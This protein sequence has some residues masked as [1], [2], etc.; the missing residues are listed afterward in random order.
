METKRYFLLLFLNI[1]FIPGGFGQDVFYQTVGSKQGLSQSSAISIWQDK[2][3]KIWIGNDALNSFDGE[4]VKVFRLSEYLDGVED[5]YIH[6]LCGNDSILFFLA[7]SQLVCFDLRME[8]FT[9]PGIRTQSIW[10]SNGFLYYV[11][12]GMF[13]KYDWKTNSSTEIIH[14]PSNIQSSQSI[15]EKEED[16]FWLGTPGGI[17]E[18]NIKE[19]AIKNRF[20]NEESILYL[21]KDS[22]DYIWVASQLGQIYIHAPNGQLKPLP[23]KNKQPQNLFNNQIYCIQE[24]V[25]GAIWIGTITGVYQ[26]TRDESEEEFLFQNHM[27]EESTIYALFSDRQGTLWIGSYYGD[28]RYF[29]PENDNYLYYGTDDNVPSQL[30]GAIIGRI[31]EDKNENL[32]LATEGSGINIKKRG[33]DSFEHLTTQNGLSQNKIRD[34][35]YDEE[36]DRLFISLYMEGVG[37]LDLK[38][39]RIHLLNNDPL[40][41]VNQKIVE[42]FLPYKNDLLLRTQDGIFKLDRNTLQIS[43]FLKEET[44]HELCS[45]IIRSIYIDDREILW[46]SSF[47]RGLFTI[48]LKN[49]TLLT[50]Y[51]DGVTERSIIPSAIISIIGDTK[52][53]L[54]FVTLKSGILRYDHTQDT[55]YNFNESNRQLVSDICYNIAFSPFG[56]LIVTSN[57]GVSLLQ[58]GFDNS[59]KILY[60]IGINPSSPLISLIGDCGLYVPENKDMIYVGGLYGL[61]CFSEKDLPREQNQY[62]LYF[63]SLQI[64]NQP[65]LPTSPILG[66]N[67][68]EV[69]KLTLSS[70]QNT[71]SLNFASS[72]YLSSRTTGYEYKLEGLDEYWTETYHNTIIYNSLRPGNYKLIVRELANTSK[73]TELVIIVK[74]PIWTTIPAILL[75]IF[76]VAFALWWIIRF[77]KSKSM[78]QASLE[79]ERREMARIEETNRNKM[80][81]FVNISNEFRNPLT[82]ITTQLDRLPQDIPLTLK[83]KLE[84]VRQQTSRM[85]DLITEM[86]DFRKIEQNK[87]KL[88]I[89]NHDIVTILLKIYDTFSDFAREK[90]LTFRFNPPNEAIPLWYDQRQM[91]KVFYNL[92]TF[93]FKISSP[94]DTV[95]VSILTG[96]GYTKIQITHRGTLLDE[97]DAKLLLDSLEAT[98]TIP[99]LSALPDGAIG[100]AFSKSVILLHKGSLSVRRENDRTILTIALPSGTSHIDMT[101]ISKE[102]EELITSSPEPIS[103]SEVVGDDPFWK[104]EIE[105]SQSKNYHMVIVEEDYEMCVLLQETFSLLYEVKVFEDA[106][107]A[108]EYTI[109]NKPDIILSE[110]NLPGISGTEMCSMLKSN[111]HTYHIPVILLSS[112][113]SELQ[114]VES[115]RSGADY[116][117]VKPFNIRILFLR[118]NYLVK[119][120]QW[121][122]HTDKKDN[123]ADMLEMATNEKEQEF[124]RT[125]NQV[126]EKNW[127]DHSFDTTI[128]YEKLG[129]GRTR[130]FNQIKEITG[131]T[132]NDYLLYLKMNKGRQLLNENRDLTIAEVAYQLGFSSPAYFSKCFKKQFGIT[133]QEYKRNN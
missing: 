1:L 125:A 119:S 53:G 37:Y 25:K 31:T 45:G 54:Y 9:L 67:L 120:R 51:G 102:G 79:L 132:P 29:N 49:N 3:G 44:L 74:P 85:Q 75:Y 55:F 12:E 76:L 130:F 13:Y 59:T 96:T 70:K 40:S 66:K 107:S 81:F 35:W 127:H 123:P 91:Q 98:S 48:D 22:K 71:L 122:T 129:I 57:K 92:L 32:Y 99:D 94:K 56:N 78:L 103:I 87:F 109:E 17:L 116:Y 52:R 46:V 47:Q 10:H 61:L 21:Y 114:N 43:R 2:I 27:L 118:C 30:H 105:N 83:N 111:F 41:T 15:I 23:I 5:S 14:L 93:L 60:H 69:D 80:D 88:K 50:N 97:D 82:L 86:L 26:L 62:G 112:Q 42:S 77:N 124:L 11:S 63:T 95:T 72:N 108:F 100:L 38:T 110:I 117:F 133:P 126:V 115:I 121:L 6:A 90:Q 24:D 106:E 4:V 36:N 20:L 34:L 113:P 58:I 68:Y 73:T 64:N 19:K 39:N 18:V 101:D 33:N 104:D 8:T 128:W 7:E 131:M 84:K 89:G 65:I 16:L 28:V